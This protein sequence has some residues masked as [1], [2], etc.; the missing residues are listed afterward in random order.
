MKDKQQLFKNIFVQVIGISCSLGI[1]FFLTPFLIRHLGVEVYGFVG[2]AN[3]CVGYLDIITIALNSMAARYIT[4]SLEQNDRELARRQFNSVFWGNIIIMAII[5]IPAILF[6]INMEYIFDVPLKHVGDIKL[7]W[8]LMFVNF[9]LTVVTSV[10]SVATFT[11]NRLDIAASIRIK[12]TLL[13][14]LLLLFLFSFLSP[15]VFFIGITMLIC[16]GYVFFLNYK[17]TKQYLPDFCI[18]QKK[19]SI[20]IV[21][22]ICKSGVWNVV[23]RL[24]GILS[25]GLDLLLANFFIDVM[26]MG[27]LSIA[28][29][30]SQ[31]ALSFFGQISGVFAPQIT[32][33]YARQDIC[34]ICEQMKFSIKFLG[35]VTSCV[36]M[37]IFAYGA[38][39]YR[40]WLPNQH[41]NTLWYLTM[42]G[43]ADLI[44]AMPLESFWNIMTATN[45]IRLPSIV[46]LLEGVLT[47]LIVVSSISYLDGIYK[48]YLIAGVSSFFAILRALFFMPIYASYCIGINRLYFYKSIV[49]NFILFAISFF[50]IWIIKSFIIINGWQDL[51]FSVCFS[52]IIIF[53]LGFFIN[54]DK[55][56][57]SLVT[58]KILKIKLRLWRR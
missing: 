52:C 35:I 46:L 4:I 14:T 20:G 15:H 42:L 28:R 38:D 33:A 45:K 50:V 51:F 29:T 2:L 12:S 41:A 21:K 47:I 36:V 8:T 30:L 54:L 39:F 13:R 58:S 1:N 32:I 6:I 27:M 10:F 7:L 48:L 5:L 57:R 55:E 53:L 22:E 43:S 40:L 34:W 31:V 37:F 56:E 9:T 49:K 44:F 16:T 26:S 3:D 23:S 19:Y 11:S 24:S 17:C 25:K 18:N